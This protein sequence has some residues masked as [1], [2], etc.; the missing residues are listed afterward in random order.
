MVRKRQ[1]KHEDEEEPVPR[2]EQG[3]HFILS[4]FALLQ[5]LYGAP[6]VDER[7]SPVPNGERPE[8]PA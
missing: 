2:K 1:S 6:D 8:L 3:K 4:G 7:L 5:K